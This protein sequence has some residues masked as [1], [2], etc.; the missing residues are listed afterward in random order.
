[1]ATNWQTGLM[2]ALRTLSQILSAGVSITAFSLL[3]YSLTFNLR[4]RVA[5]TF[6]IIMFC[7][8]IVFTAESLGGTSNDVQLINFWLHTQWLGVILLPAAYFHFSDALLATTGKPSRGKRRL[9][10]VLLYLASLFFLGLLALGILLGDLNTS[11]PPAPYLEPNFFTTMFTLYYAGIMVLAWYNFARAFLRTTTPTSRRRIVYLIGGA[12]APALGSFPYLLY[13]SSFAANHQLIF[14]L[15]VFLANA[16]VIFLTVLMAYAVAFFGVSWPDRVVRRRLVKWLLR[17]PVTASVTL[18]LVTIVRRVGEAF[19]IPYSAV[20]P[21]VMVGVILLSQYLI[22]LFSPLWEHWFFFGRDRSDVTLLQTAENRMLTEADLRQFLEMILA[23][24]CDRLQ[25]PGAYIASFN[26]TGIDQVVTIGKTDFFNQGATSEIL[27]KVSENGNLPQI[28]RWGEDTLVT[29]MDGDGEDG[30]LFGLLGVSSVAKNEFDPDQLAALSRLAQR[31]SMA[32]RDIR[33]QREVFRSL[34][35]L[36]S[37]VEYIQRIR[38]ASSYDSSHLLEEA[39]L[40]ESD[41]SQWVKDALT[42][43]W[44]GPKLTENPLMKLQVVQD[45]ANQHDGNQANALR[46]VLKKAIEQMKPEGERH[47]TGEWILYNILEMKFLEGKKVREVARKLAL[48]EAD[49]YRKQR[50]AIEE[51]SKKILDMELDHHNGSVI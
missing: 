18:G 45:T 17:G 46:A 7:M 41:I 37:E 6:S 19:G 25:A 29:L 31:A 36:T 44:G 42:H 51:V 39:S 2:V 21:I 1:M 35:S 15:L 28:F 8:V 23:A 13:S 4:D 14:W 16:L 43:Y 50:V 34:E 26:A 47:F 5:R 33:H 9:L 20:V 48:S 22:T 27:N 38:A 49:L 10:V 11:L 3:L 40:P 32:L 12:V 30:E 24:V